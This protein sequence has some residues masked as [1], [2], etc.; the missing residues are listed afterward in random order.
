MRMWPSTLPAS[1]VL[2]GA[3][4]VLAADVQLPGLTVP[5]QYASNGDAVKQIFTD[6]YNSYKY[7]CSFALITVLGGTR[8][9]SRSDLGHSGRVDM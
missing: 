2:L 1:L 9:C 7:V 4:F 6:S 5:S 3:P 8:K